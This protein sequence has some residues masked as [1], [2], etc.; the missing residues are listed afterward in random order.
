ML[1]QL[2]YRNRNIVLAGVTLLFT[3]LAYQLSIKEAIERKQAY[4]EA[5]SQS[6]KLAGA[7]QQM[8]ELRKKIMT[9]DQSLGN[10]NGDTTDLPQLILEK[11]STYCKKNGTE[12]KK[13]PGVSRTDE[14]NYQLETTQFVVKGNFIDLLKLVYGFEQEYNLG[15]LVSVEFNI[16][17]ELRSRKQ[18][19]VATLFVQNIKK[20]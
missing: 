14:Q 16:Q 20:A 11:V 9:L 1:K 12:L 6:A 3:I 4:E 18:Y 17:K 15:K 5:I 19:L 2:T 8:E 10:L 7:P 13:F